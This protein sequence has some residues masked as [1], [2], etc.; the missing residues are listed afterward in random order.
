MAEN[1][2]IETEEKLRD[3][4]EDF[5]GGMAAPLADRNDEPQDIIARTT[6]HRLWDRGVAITN[7]ELEQA[8]ADAQHDS[9][10]RAGDVIAALN[11][12]GLRIVPVEPTGNMTSAGLQ[13]IRFD[14]DWRVTTENVYK[15]MIGAGK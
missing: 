5:L 3:A 15:A 13:A 14:T 11:E 8:L 12:A 10:A 7:V 4:A 6:D 9:L 1:S 2:K